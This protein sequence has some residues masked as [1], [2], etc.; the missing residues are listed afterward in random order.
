MQYNEII[1]LN[2]YIKEHT[3][4]STQHNVK[5]EEYENVLAVFGKGWNRYNFND[6]LEKL[7]TENEEDKFIRCRN[8]FYVC[9]SRAICNLHILFTEKL[10]ET[11]LNKLKDMV[12]EENVVDIVKECV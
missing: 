1:P 10:S 3:P 6:M 9:V 2:E 12:G 11:S 8:L 4:F 5:G 7:G